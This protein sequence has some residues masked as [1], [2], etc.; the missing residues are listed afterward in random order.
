MKFKNIILS[1]ILLFVTWMLLNNKFDIQI[2]GVGLVVSLF[3][4]FA[5]CSKCEIFS[6][7]NVSPKGIIY[8]F[9]YF[10]VFMGELI[11]SNLDVARRVIAPSLPINP[12]IV[13]VETQLKTKIGRLVLANSITLTPGTLSMDIKDDKIFV[14][15]INVTD[16]DKENATKEI[17]AKFEKYLKVIYG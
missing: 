10:F 16:A 11:K 7:V 4:S 14:H 13:E 3:V 9:L 8:F 15:W 17:V 12:G 6:K 5:V 1:F 2:V